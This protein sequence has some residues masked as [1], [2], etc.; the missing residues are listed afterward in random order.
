M[1]AVAVGAGGGRIGRRDWERRQAVRGAGDVHEGTE[2]ATCVDFRA[3]AGECT[4]AKPARSL[5]EVTDRCALSHAGLAGHQ[6]GPA[7]SA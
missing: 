7:P 6:R 1:E 5:N 4:N 2:R 3:F